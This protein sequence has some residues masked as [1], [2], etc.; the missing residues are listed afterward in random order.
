ML[1]NVKIIIG[2][3]VFSDVKIASLVFSSHVTSNFAHPFGYYVR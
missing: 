2:D 3:A 1:N